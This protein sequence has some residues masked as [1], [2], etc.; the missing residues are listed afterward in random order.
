MRSVLMPGGNG[1]ITVTGRV[2]QGSAA[3]AGIAASRQAARIQTAAR[4]IKVDSLPA[5]LGKSAARLHHFAT[6]K[7][8]V[9]F[10]DH[11]SV[12]SFFLTGPPPHAYPR[13]SVRPP[14]R[15]G[16]GVRGL[17]AD[18]SGERRTVA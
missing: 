10:A 8:L 3:R 5:A 16:G 17:P 14:R 18:R 2:G 7:H 12:V 13:I 11:I 15:L 9:W 1:Q 6:A 4:L